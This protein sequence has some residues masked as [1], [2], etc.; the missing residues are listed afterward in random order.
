[1]SKDLHDCKN[2]RKKVS[3]IELRATT[4]SKGSFRKLKPQV[5]VMGSLSVQCIRRLQVNMLE[6]PP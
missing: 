3:I 6:H 5:M 2:T 1:M 4:A